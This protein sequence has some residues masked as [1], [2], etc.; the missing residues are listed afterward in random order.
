MAL[1]A[2]PARILRQ[3]LTESILLSLAGGLAGLSVAF[4]GTRLILHFAFET[5]TAVSIGATPSWPVVVFAFA[6]ASITG[7][8][9]GMAPVWLATQVDP[10]ALRGTNRST[11]EAGSRPRRVLV[12]LQAASSVVL[13]SSAGLLLAALRNLEHQDLGFRAG[14]QTVIG[15]DPVLAGYEPGQLEPLYP[16]SNFAGSPSGCGLGCVRAVLSAERG[17]LR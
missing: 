8:L 15:I 2:R 1:G 16:D 3:A 4:V 14:G 9:S 11:R 6:L 17:R 5:T 10:M 7:V 13:L 12:V